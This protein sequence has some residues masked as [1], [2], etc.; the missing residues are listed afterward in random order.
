M[1]VYPFQRRKVAYKVFEEI[2]NLNPPGRFLM[3]K[4]REWLECDGTKTISKI[5]QALREL[6]SNGPVDEGTLQN[7]Y[8]NAL[9]PNARTETPNYSSTLNPGLPP[10][11]ESSGDILNVDSRIIDLNTTINRIHIISQSRNNT[12]A[13]ENAVNSSLSAQTD[14]SLNKLNHESLESKRSNSDGVVQSAPNDNRSSKFNEDVLHLKEINKSPKALSPQDV[15]QQLKVSTDNQHNE[16]TRKRLPTQNPKQSS[17][18]SQKRLPDHH[19]Q[20]IMPLSY[21]GR[22]FAT[23]VC[24]DES[25]YIFQEIAD[26]GQCEDALL[27]LPS[28]MASLCKR[29]VDLQDQLDEHDR[30]LYI[31]TRHL[32]NM[33]RLK[34]T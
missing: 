5:S 11:D 14:T 8:S 24:S 1:S 7:N 23:S 27:Y 18:K 25:K 31:N 9:P 30:L 12:C 15:S 3:L 19:Q 29:V 26:L 10:V 33:S 21:I 2:Q 32:S 4:D 17:S 22:S 13:G 34:R 28:V 16:S 20:V 6:E